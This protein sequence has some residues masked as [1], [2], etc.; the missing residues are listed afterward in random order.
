MVSTFA[1]QRPPTFVAACLAAAGAHVLATLLVSLV[2]VPLT[3][4]TWTAIV[5]SGDPSDATLRLVLPWLLVLA[6]QP[7]AAAWIAQRGLDLFDAGSVTYAR[8]CSA[9][10]LGLVVTVSSAVALPAET[11]L[12]VLGYAWTGALAAAVVLTGPHRAVR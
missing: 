12:P 9:M 10:I 5:F 4:V 1:S 2:M 7:L 6:L 8:A 11:A 3:V